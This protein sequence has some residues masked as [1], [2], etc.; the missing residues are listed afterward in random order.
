MAT[1]TPWT[2]MR[3]SG[4]FNRITRSIPSAAWRLRLHASPCRTD[5]G[6]SHGT[7]PR[8]IRR[9]RESGASG[10]LL[11]SAAFPCEEVVPGNDVDLFPEGAEANPHPA[12]VPQ[13]RDQSGHGLERARQKD[14]PIADFE[15]RRHDTIPSH[16][17]K[18]NQPQRGAERFVP[19][20]EKIFSSVA[21]QASPLTPF[22]APAAMPPLRSRCTQICIFI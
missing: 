20:G 4:I 1:L 16:G 11:V 18:R 5:A 12:Q 19:A 22:A 15:A 6:T 8:T 13:L 17:F 9:R 7:S 2:C 3:S 14:H 10:R 21:G